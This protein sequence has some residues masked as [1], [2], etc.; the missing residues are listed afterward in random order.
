[1]TCQHDRNAKE[2]RRR[3]QLED[4]VGYQD[5]HSKGGGGAGKGKGMGGKGKGT[6]DTGKGG[7]GRQGMQGKGGRGE[8]VRMARN[9]G[10]VRDEEDGTLHDDDDTML[11]DPEIDLD[12]VHVVISERRIGRQLMHERMI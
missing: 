1:M 4:A 8:P 10:D 11:L 5:G 3:Q 2:Q 7:M 6:A 9:D 12:E